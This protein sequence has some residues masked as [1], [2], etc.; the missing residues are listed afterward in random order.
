VCGIGVILGS[1]RDW[2][3]QAANTLNLAQAHRGPDDQGVQVRI[4]HSGLAL[5]LAHR[6]LSILD[7]SQNGHQPMVDEV[8]GNAIVFNGEIYNHLSLAKELELKGERFRSSSDTEVVL[9]A[10]KHFSTADFL[11]KLRG[12]FAFALWDEHQQRI[13]FARD[14]CGIKPL[15]YSAV[16][17]SFVCASEVGA[18]VETGLVEGQVSLEGL[19][20]YLAFGSVQA[21]LTIYKDVKSLLPGHMMWVTGDG[22]ISQPQSYWN[23]SA[24]GSEGGEEA[25]E[26]WL[27]ESVRRHLI[28]DVP[29][30]L[31]L[32]GG[33]DSTALATLAS[34][35]SDNQLNTYTLSFPDNPTYSEG[36]RAAAIAGRVGSKHSSIELTKSQ[37]LAQLPGY[38]DS[39]DQ[40]SDDGLNIYLVSKYIAA[41]GVRTCIHG[42][43][44][45]EL[46]GGYP[47]FRELPIAKNFELMPRFARELISRAIDG[48]GVARTKFAA[49]LRTDLSLLE[50]FL[51][52]RTN[53]SYE[54]RRR[55]LGVDP[56]LGPLGMPAEWMTYTT[57]QLANLIDP[58]ASI[59]ILE[60]AHYGANKLL[61]DGDVMS[62]AN[63]LELRFPLLDVDLIRAVLN[64]P[65]RQKV[66]SKATPKKALVQAVS[67]MPID[68]IDKTK[69]GFTLPISQWITEMDISTHESDRQDW[70]RL[71]IDP[72]AVEALNGEILAGK[73]VTNSGWIRRW[74]LVALRQWMNRL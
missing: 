32:S 62:M 45:D 9:K 2:V 22:Q 37:L 63:G 67:N 21:P 69:R 41:R 6:R 31:L 24:T 38:Y 20:S 54:Q 58:M 50:M 73:R 70:G 51:V 17:G 5:G 52:R 40:P 25:I 60:L 71:G 59:S 28:A 53:F 7:L 3:I 72:L 14:P 61:Q 15:Y 39:T 16:K 13:L 10:Y 74:Q 56:P 36:A 23:W 57:T 27:A 1:S 8:S 55:L 29:V 18:I 64:T 49:L 66:G 19:D 68:L 30:G 11:G 44:G 12:M 26:Y 34:R 47:S 4:T 33:V 46:F 48:N 65:Q 35:E 43:G 42:V